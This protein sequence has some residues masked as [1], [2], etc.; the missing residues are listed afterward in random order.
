MTDGKAQELLKELVIHSPN[1][2]GYSLQHGVIRYQGRIWVGS[3]FAVQAKIITALH[4]SAVGGHSGQQT[5]YQRIKKSF[6][7]KGMKQNVEQFI[8]QC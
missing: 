3:N 7:W 8:K 6:C 4:S 5:T 2:Q 1:A